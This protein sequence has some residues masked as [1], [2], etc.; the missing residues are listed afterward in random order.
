V[1][2][3]LSSQDFLL[4][5]LAE[6][7]DGELSQEMKARVEAL[8]KTPGQEDIPAHFQAMRG[9]LQLSLQSYYLKEDEV[10][11]LKAFVQDPAVKATQENAKIDALGRGEFMSTL[12]RRLALVAIAAAAIGFV[13][14]KFGPRGE[15]KFKPLEFLGY[16]ALALEEDPRDRLDLPSG[17]MKEIRQYL[18]AYPGLEFKPKVMKTMP[19][20]WKPEG[21][22]IIDYEIA[23]VA[24]VQFVN[25][26]SKEKL[27]H[28]SYAGELKDLP[29]AEPGNMRGLIFQT[30]SSDD[31]NLVAFEGPKGVVSILAGR[32]SAPELAE[33]A[34]NGTK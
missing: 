5:Y 4:A 27:F 12:I 25:T 10:Q 8:V 32:R 1:Q 19:A 23:K 33:I 13:V 6:Y 16:E 15:A 11:S 34:L 7:L 30:Y 21:A 9:R 17:D 31:L 18:A 14:W 20:D 28:F 26:N 3:N 24:L 22:T 2:S 29:Q